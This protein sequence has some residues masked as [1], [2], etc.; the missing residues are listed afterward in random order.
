MASVTFS[1]TVGGDGSTV[2]DDDSPSTGLGN[3]GSILRLV[4]MMAQVVAVASNVVSVAGGT[5]QD[6]IDAAASADAALASQNAA[7]ASVAQVNTLGAATGLQ[8]TGAA[9]MVNAA[10]PPT[11]GQALVATS[12]TTA[13]WQAVSPPDFLIMAQGII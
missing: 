9:V 1:T 3:G 7:A 13:S 8:T 5:T 11:T 2:T 12:A 6:V 10:S 4:P